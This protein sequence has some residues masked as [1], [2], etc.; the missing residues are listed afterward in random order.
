MERGA[1]SDAHFRSHT[2]PLVQPTLHEPVQTA[3]QVAAVQPML[4]LPATVKLQV[5]PLVQFRLA[6]LPAVTV[7]VLPPL[8]TPLHE[9]PQLPLHVPFVHASEQ[10]AVAGS[11]P[12]LL[13][14]PLPPHA[15][16]AVTATAARM[17]FIG[18]LRR[19][20]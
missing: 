17:C 12:I 18:T 4:L 7:H 8:Q 9:L 16:S 19:C 1:A 5:A 20:H 11:Q 3:W 14:E 13:N 15:A 10:L 2:P 6:L